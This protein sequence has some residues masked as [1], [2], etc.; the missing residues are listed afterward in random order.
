MYANELRTHDC[1]ARAHCS[2][3]KLADRDQNLIGYLGL[4]PLGAQRQM[5]T[6]GAFYSLDVVLCGP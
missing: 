2:D 1:I 4:E 6:H 5:L 3:E